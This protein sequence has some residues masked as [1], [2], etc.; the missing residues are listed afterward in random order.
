[1]VHLT[2]EKG[3]K[4]SKK[5][6]IV[7]ASVFAVILVIAAIAAG[8]LN[9][10]VTQGGKK[11]FQIEIVSERDGYSEITDHKSDAEYLGEF[12]RTFEGC[13]WQESDYG[14]YITGFNGMQE[15]LDNQYWWCVSVNGQSSVTGADEIPLLD[16]DVYNFTLMQGWEW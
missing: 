3:T 10:R 7:F 11:E 16:G 12:L 6:K 8:A 15:D 2:R 9:N 1:M 5:K 4:M 14:I 13:E